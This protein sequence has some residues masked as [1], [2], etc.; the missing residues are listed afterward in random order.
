MPAIILKQSLW[1]IKFF[2]ALLIIGL[3]SNLT[4]LAKAHAN[5]PLIVY[6]A[7]GASVTQPVVDRFSALNDIEVSVVY[8]G[9]DLNDRLKREGRYTPADLAIIVGSDNLRE[10]ATSGLTKKPLF[11]KPF[12]IIP[13]AFRSKEFAWIGLSKR[14]YIAYVSADLPVDQ[15]PKTWF[16]LVQPQWRGQLCLPN[17][18]HARFVG[19]VSAF[20]HHFSE[21]GEHV[22]LDWLNALKTN[23]VNNSEYSDRARLRQV[24]NGECQITIADSHH[25]GMIAQGTKED[26]ELYAKLF[27]IFL[28]FYP[29]DQLSIDGDGG[30]YTEISGAFLTLNEKNQDNAIKLLEFL[31]SMEAQ[32]LYTH[33]TY[34][35]PANPELAAN[36]TVEAWGDFI[37]DTLARDTIFD[38]RLQALKLI[39]LVN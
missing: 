30:V 34:E 8:T 9:R 13:E 17:F 39:H 26:R 33:P 4:G 15:R 32:S 2:I 24:A 12:E 23:R 3:A 6:S 14:A 20:A 38:L 10:A 29:Q 19:L 31:V 1:G 36:E 37:P 16:D 5:E 25:Y 7:R 28:S 11:Y 27:P 22:T 21:F 35:Y 18:N